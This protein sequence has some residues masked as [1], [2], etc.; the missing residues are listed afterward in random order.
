MAKLTEI[1]PV[2]SNWNLELSEMELSVLYTILRNVGG[3]PRSSFRLYSQRILDCLAETVETKIKE[4][5]RIKMQ[6]Y[7]DKRIQKMYFKNVTEEDK[8]LLND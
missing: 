3:E 7:L 2:K 1:K 8:V 4:P 5:E 6:D